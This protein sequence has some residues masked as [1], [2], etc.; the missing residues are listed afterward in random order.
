[1]RGTTGELQP[2]NSSPGVRT[3]HMLSTSVST[4]NEVSAYAEY[5]RSTPNEV[6]YDYLTKH[7]LS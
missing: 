1:M 4:P 2:G 6:Y 5:M 3:L 7:L